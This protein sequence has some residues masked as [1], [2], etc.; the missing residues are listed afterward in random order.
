VCPSRCRLVARHLA[1]RPQTG[2]ASADPRDRSDPTWGHSACANAAIPPINLRPSQ[3]FLPFSV[4]A[5]AQLAPVGA[6][7]C[8]V[9]RRKAASPGASRS[10]DGTVSR[11]FPR[12]L[13]ASHPR[14]VGHPPY[15]PFHHSSGNIL[16]P[17]ASLCGNTTDRHFILLLN[18]QPQESP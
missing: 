11:S 8:S 9:S 13:I 16:A 6:D 3:A 2:M 5:W 14:V 7:E 10:P 12:Q 1:S 4:R 15:S 17:N 18:F